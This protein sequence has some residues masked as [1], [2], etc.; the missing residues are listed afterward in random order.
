MRASIRVGDACVG[1]PIRGTERA[2]RRFVGCNDD[3]DAFLGMDFFGLT[4]LRERFAEER[5]TGMSG[6][7]DER[8]KL[9]FLRK[10]VERRRLAGSKISLHAP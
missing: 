2:R 6:P 5:S 3:I 4:Q 1:Y 10:D 9:N 8:G 7:D